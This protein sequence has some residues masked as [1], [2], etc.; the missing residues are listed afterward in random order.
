MKSEKALSTSLWSSME[1]ATNI[2]GCE[3]YGTLSHFH[4]KLWS[5]AVETG[6]RQFIIMAPVTKVCKFCLILLKKQTGN[7]NS[8]QMPNGII[9]EQLKHIFD[10][11]RHFGELAPARSPNWRLVAIF[12]KN[13][14]N[15]LI[16]REIQ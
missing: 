8:L 2:Q 11:N 14:Q 4:G 1:L 7:Q 10:K 6:N 12:F 15:C 13:G 3:N 5:E 9:L 16:H